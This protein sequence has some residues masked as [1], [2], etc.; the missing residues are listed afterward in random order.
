M[1]TMT[2]NKETEAEI[3]EKKQTEKSAKREARAE[4]KAKAKIEANKTQEALLPLR[5]RMQTL[6]REY[7]NGAYFE[8]TRRMDKLLHGLLR[9]IEVGCQEAE[10][11]LARI[12]AG[13]G[14]CQP[15]ALRQ[16]LTD[17]LWDT[18]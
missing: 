5:N 3:K 10:K 7:E 12:S 14:P 15:S 11:D 2:T 17:L 13:E 1:K 16:R 4:L 9:A 6:I 8:H 18:Q